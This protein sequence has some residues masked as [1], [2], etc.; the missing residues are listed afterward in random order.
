MSELKY[1]PFEE[2]SEGIKDRVTNYWTER[3]ESF[4]EQ[5]QHELNSSKA[6]KWL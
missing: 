5:R 4:F 3:A 6:G 2:E 1:I